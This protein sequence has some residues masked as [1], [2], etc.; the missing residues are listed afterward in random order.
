MSTTRYRNYVYN[1]MACLLGARGS[2]EWTIPMDR[3]R[4]LEEHQRSPIDTVLKYLWGETEAKTKNWAK[5]GKLPFF[6][7]LHIIKTHWKRYI[8]KCMRRKLKTRRAD[9]N[10]Y[11]NIYRIMHTSVNNTIS[12]LCSFKSSMKINRCSTLPCG[13]K[14]NPFQVMNY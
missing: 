10:T 8:C 9:K 3:E 13:N 12:R 14:V 5:W 11:T 1:Y 6:S 7:V 4:D 2:H